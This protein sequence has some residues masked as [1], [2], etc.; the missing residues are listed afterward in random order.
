M[1]ENRKLKKLRE[2]MKTYNDCTD[3]TKMLD[4]EK[5]PIGKPMEFVA[6]DAG[7]K[8]VASVCSMIIALEDVLDKP[9]EYHYKPD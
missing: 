7:V 4:C 1:A 2:A 5:C 9:K 3:L 6:H 8:V